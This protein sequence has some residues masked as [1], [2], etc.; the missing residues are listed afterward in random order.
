MGTTATEGEQLL[1]S[2][3]PAVIQSR[4]LRVMERP[5]RGSAAAA[6]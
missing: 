5:R 2:S 6:R 1:E 4:S 3:G